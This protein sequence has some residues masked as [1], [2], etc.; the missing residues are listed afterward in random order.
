MI[1]FEALGE[2]QQTARTLAP[3]PKKLLREALNQL[4]E[5]PKAGKQ[6]LDEFAHLRSLAIARYRLIYRIESETLIFLVR[7]AHRET[8]YEQLE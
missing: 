5:N 8:V 7:F 3:R 1:R 2:F 6:L 4:R